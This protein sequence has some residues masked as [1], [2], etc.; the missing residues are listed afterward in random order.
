MD[1]KLM[2][3]KY[4]TGEGLDGQTGQAIL[5][6]AEKISSRANLWLWLSVGLLLLVVLVSLGLWGYRLNLEKK[7]TSLSGQIEQ[8]ESKRDLE[9]E[10]EFS[11]LNS[12]IENLKK[13][14]AKRIYPSK[15]LALLEELTLPQVQFTDLSIDFI[16]ST[17][18]LKARAVDYDV[19]AKQ[20]VVFE[21]DE[22]VKS[23]SFS[24]VNMDEEGGVSSDFSIELS[25]SFLLSQ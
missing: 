11:R 24:Q 1:I 13:I 18:D 12:T 25:P 16:Q 8:L 19:I 21:S 9:L 2:P 14:F 23:I 4:K 10:A 20:V 17:F 5:S 15:V 7:S 22:R 6:L 3:E